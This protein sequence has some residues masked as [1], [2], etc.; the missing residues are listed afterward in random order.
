MWKYKIYWILI[1]Q[2]STDA[3]I[4]DSF[5][6]M[7]L[8]FTIKNGTLSLN[9]RG[10]VQISKLVGWSITSLWTWRQF[11][12]NHRS[13]DEMQKKSFSL[14]HHYIQESNQS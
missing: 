14:E 10:M 12:G 8:I 6:H 7:L 5:F 13:P 4:P 11:H 1:E 3:F 2:W 9:A